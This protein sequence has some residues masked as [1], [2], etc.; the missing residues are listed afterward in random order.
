M[1]RGYKKIEADRGERIAVHAPGGGQG[2]ALRSS[3]GTATRAATLVIART[4]RIEAGV[5]AGCTWPTR[6]TP[7]HS[8]LD[9]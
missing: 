7:Q 3:T 6:Y 1:S 4:Q 8:R 9:T 2:Q 5:F